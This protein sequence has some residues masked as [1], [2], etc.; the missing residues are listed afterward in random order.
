MS[1]ILVLIRAHVPWTEIE[2]VYN[3]AQEMFH[4]LAKVIGFQ[5]FSVWQ[6][7]VYDGDSLIVLEYVD[8]DAA[9][10]GLECW[11]EALTKV[12]IKMPFDRP[13]DVMR[14]EVDKRFGRH[15]SLCGPNTYLSQSFRI[16]EPGHVQELVNDVEMVFDTLAGMPGIISGVYGPNAALNEE[17]I[18]IA[19][20]LSEK[21]YRSSLPDRDWGYR[22]DFFN[23]LA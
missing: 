12:K 19:T 2:T 9:E 8:I 6:E 10:R 7:S 11:S 21:S 17:I 1:E 23:R 4:H 13:A 20:W 18:G 14:V 16:A 5:G 15:L 3:S 22:I